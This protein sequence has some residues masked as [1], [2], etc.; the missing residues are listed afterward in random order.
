MSAQLPIKSPI[1]ML[2]SISPTDCSGAAQYQ[3][4]PPKPDPLPPQENLDNSTV[5]SILS[6]H[7]VIFGGFFFLL[8]G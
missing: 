2:Y 7:K 6:G 3:P 5:T 1:L 4:T 8:M